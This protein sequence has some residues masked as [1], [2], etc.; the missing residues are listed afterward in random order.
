MSRMTIVMD[1]DDLGYEQIT[2]QLHKL[3]S[4]Y[5]ISDMTGEDTI[6]RE[7]ALFKG[8]RRSGTPPRGDR[9]RQRVS[10]QSGG[11][12]QN[13]LTIEATGDADKLGAME[14]LFRAYG[15]KQLT[16]TGKVAMSRGARIRGFCRSSER[17]TTRR[18][19]AVWR[20]ALPLQAFLT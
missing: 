1:A 8:G 17:R 2:K 20:A 13:S 6:E 5:K 16:R 18:C 11:P 4:T 14:D 19:G 7:L 9:D 10:R 12:R 15:I 3:V